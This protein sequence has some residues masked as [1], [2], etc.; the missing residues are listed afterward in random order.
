MAKKKKSAKSITEIGRLTRTEGWELAVA[1]YAFGDAPALKRIRTVLREKRFT[2]KD[3]EATYRLINHWTDLGLVEDSARQSEEG[4]RRLSLVDLIWIKTLAE[5][6][7][8]GVPLETLQAVRNSIF[9]VPKNHAT[10]PDFEYAVAHCLV[11]KNS[12]FFLL[13]FS[14]GRADVIDQDQLD[15]NKALGLLSGESY[16]TISINAIC[17][18]V[19]PSLSIPINPISTHLD[20]KELSVVNA[21]REGRYDQIEVHSRDGKVNR[22][23]LKERRQGRQEKIDELISKISFGEVTVKF[24]NGKPVLTEVVESRKV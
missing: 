21:I 20:E 17:K 18:Q 2:V 6:R 15:F 9:K 13:V 1:E 4:W 11:K 3:S 19:I 22:I 23:E 8:F 14:E 16:L 24:Q 10:R 12:S 7:S 5:M